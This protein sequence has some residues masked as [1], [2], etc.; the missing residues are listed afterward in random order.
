MYVRMSV[1]MYVGCMDVMLPGHFRDAGDGAQAFR[2]AGMVTLSH[3]PFDLWDSLE[4][5]NSL[6]PTSLMAAPQPALKH[7]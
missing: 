1:C 3:S 5:C 6:H 2:H 7:K 4:R